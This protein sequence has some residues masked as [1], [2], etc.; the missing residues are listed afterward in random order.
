MAKNALISPVTNS[1][2]QLQKDTTKEKSEDNGGDSIMNMNEPQ[3]M[4]YWTEKR[5]VKNRELKG[6]GQ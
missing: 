4:W 6:F 1:P 5:S 2:K 3:N